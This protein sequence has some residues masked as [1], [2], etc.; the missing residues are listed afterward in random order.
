M[1]MLPPE[2]SSWKSPKAFSPEGVNGSSEVWLFYSFFQKWECLAMNPSVDSTIEICQ[3]LLRGY[4]RQNIF[5]MNGQVNSYLHPQ[6]FPHCWG[7]WGKLNARKQLVPPL[8]SSKS[9]C[10]QS[11]WP[12]SGSYGA[13]NYAFSASKWKHKGGS[14][15]SNCFPLKQ[16]RTRNPL[17][18][19][20]FVDDTAVTLPSPAGTAGTHLPRASACAPLRAE[21]NAHRGNTSK[22]SN[23][24]TYK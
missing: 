11:A 23:Y 21:Q 20:L 14:S 2:N 13:P 8:F 7:L 24:W 17:Q 9:S 16:R 10:L 18:S 3:I 4:Q 19:L 5:V 1:P 6:W 12:F 15:H 22:T